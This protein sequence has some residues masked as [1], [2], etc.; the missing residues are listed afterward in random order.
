[1]RAS[2]TN[3]WICRLDTHSREPR[4]IGESEQR[5]CLL[6]ASEESPLS[7]SRERAALAWTEAPTLIAETRAPD[8]LCDEVRRR[9]D[10]KALADPTA[11]VGM[12]NLWNRP[13]TS[14]RYGHP[15]DA[16]R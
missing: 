12:I 6:N 13:A 16:E 14:L 3:D 2:E 15:V 7:T 1:M 10:D 5:I 11:P 4:R 9:F 8:I